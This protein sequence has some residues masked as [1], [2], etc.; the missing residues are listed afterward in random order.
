[1]KVVLGVDVGGSAISAG[2][3]TE[4]GAVLATVTSPTHAD[5]PGTAVLTVGR[6]VHDLRARAERE[7]LTPVAIGVGLPGI[8][9]ARRGT[10]IRSF[11]YVPEL[12]HVA[13]AEH[14]GTATGLPV[15]V[16][17]DV[18]ALALSAWMFGPGRGARSLALMA[19]GTGVGGGVILDGTLVRGA[20]GCAGE[21][22]HIT[23]DRAGPTCVCGARG[24]LC[25]FVGGR[26]IEAEARQ[27][28]AAA[29][30]SRLL[31]LAGGNPLAITA[32][33]V[34]Q[35]AAQDDGLAQ[36]IVQRALDALG[37]GLGAV[38]NMLDPEIVVVTGGVAESLVGLEA[39]V[40]RRAARYT[41][42]QAFDGARIVLAPAGKH[43]TVR[44]GAALAIYERG[45]RAAPSVLT[46]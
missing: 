21:L 29:P 1:M 19:L 4:D 23:V 41:L 12:A 33:L 24:C 27:R 42:P 15:F 13:L 8:I 36:A 9:D 39:E 43:E 37:A 3:V 46:S 35:A 5:G 30:D 28:A 14:L 45:R 18:N 34:F 2:L 25:V 20:H 26:A 44:G 16:D 7:G 11:G 31:A 17:N 32:R 6:L 40:R 10:M 38:Q 22:G